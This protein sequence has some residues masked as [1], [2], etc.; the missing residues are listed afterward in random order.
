M[1][2]HPMLCPNAGVRAVSATCHPR[3]RGQQ[4]RKLHGEYE[5][6]RRA[7]AQLFQG[8]EILKA[9]SVGVDI[10]RVHRALQVSYFTRRAYRV[11]QG[12]TC[13]LLSRETT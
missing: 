1:A 13:R 9:E 4:V 11:V 10:S 12:P 7:G 2:I 6:G 3:E 8:L 5:L